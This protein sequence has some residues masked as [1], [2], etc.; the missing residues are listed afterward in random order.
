[1]A[2]SVCTELVNVSFCW[3][4]NTVRHAS[5]LF[6]TSYTSSPGC[7]DLFE[8]LSLRP[9]LLNVPFQR[10]N[11]I[12]SFDPGFFLLVVVATFLYQCF[13]IIPFFDCTA[14]KEDQ[15]NGSS[16]SW[17]KTPAS[18][19][20]WHGSSKGKICLKVAVKKHFYWYQ[21]F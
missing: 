15:T 8:P 19:E 11:L 12:C 16:I 1:M 21:L 10:N 13:L 17:R 9:M 14:W 2:S 20:T 6:L 7:K 4:A 5:T 3:L 18:A